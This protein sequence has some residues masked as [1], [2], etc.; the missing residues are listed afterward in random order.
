MKRLIITLSVLLGLTAC[1]VT[2]PKEVKPPVVDYES[3]NRVSYYYDNY[4]TYTPVM[5]EMED[6]AE[7]HCSKYGKTAIYG[8]Q[9]SAKPEE[10]FDWATLMPKDTTANLYDFECMKFRSGGSSNRIIVTDPTLMS[11]QN[12]MLLRRIIRNQPPP[13]Q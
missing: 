6:L 4:E 10:G 12:N 7:A 8:G 13:F 9:R 2:E 1:A 3:K 5:P 11:Q